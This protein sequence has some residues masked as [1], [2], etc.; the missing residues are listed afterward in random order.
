[1]GFASSS[2][3]GIDEKGASRGHVARTEVG[4]GANAEP[5]TGLEGTDVTEG[6]PTSVSPTGGPRGSLGHGGAPEGV[7]KVTKRHSM[8]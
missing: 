7:G 2:G 1:M 4:T 8:A 3:T 6:R 5:N